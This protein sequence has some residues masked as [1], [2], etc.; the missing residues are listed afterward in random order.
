MLSNISTYK[1]NTESICSFGSVPSS[2]LQKT[3]TKF[4]CLNCKMIQDGYFQIYG[5]ILLMGIVNWG[6]G[7]WINKGRNV[8]VQKVF[9]SKQLFPLSVKEG[10][11]TI[12]TGQPLYV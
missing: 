2:M 12:R 9:N 4:C 6:G 1:S 3:T 10:H 8:L 7:E 11:V 5:T